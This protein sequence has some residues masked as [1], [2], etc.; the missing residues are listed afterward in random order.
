MPVRFYRGDAE[1]PSKRALRQQESEA[2][3]LALAL[4]SDGADGIMFRFAV[5]TEPDGAVRRIVFLALRDEAGRVECFWPIPLGEG[6]GLSD[7]RE[8]RRN[9]GALLQLLLSVGAKP[10]ARLLQVRNRPRMPGKPVQ[11]HGRPADAGEVSS[12]GH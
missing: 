2:E 5:E 11:N 10:S 7:G 1:D 3:Q 8:G 4:G 6:L 9:S 12:D